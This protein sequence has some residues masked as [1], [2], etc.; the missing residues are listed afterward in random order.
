MTSNDWD[1]NADNMPHGVSTPDLF[2]GELFGDELMDIYHSA[3]G[4][5]DSGKSCMNYCLCKKSGV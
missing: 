5:M 3:E 1:S 2:G 4:M